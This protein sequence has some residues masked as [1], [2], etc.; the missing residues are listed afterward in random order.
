MNYHLGAYKCIEVIFLTEDFY[1]DFSGGEWRSVDEPELPVTAGVQET[2]D[3]VPP[4]R[5]L[6]APKQPVLTL[7]L[8]IC[9]LL[10]LAAF[11]LKCVGGDTYN[12]ARGWY[13]TQLND[14]AVFGG[15][16]GFSLTGLF[17]STPDEA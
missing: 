12:S 2:E 16:N 1:E 3:V 4:K 10:G 9:V 13:L 17:D 8:V 7:Q 15:G 5:L 6:A 14:T 11:G